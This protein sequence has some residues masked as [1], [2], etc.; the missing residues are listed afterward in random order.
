MSKLI[1]KKPGSLSFHKSSNID[2][3]D[4]GRMYGILSKGDVLDLDGDVIR[5]SAIKSFMEKAKGDVIRIPM[6]VEHNP[7]KVVKTLTVG[8]DIVESNGD[9]ITDTKFDITDE[10]QQK[11]REGVQSRKYT[12]MSVGGDIL[13]CHRGKGVRYDI[14][15][16]NLREASIVAQPAN[17]QALIQV[18]KSADVDL[19]AN[20]MN[21]KSWKEVVDE[22]ITNEM[23][24]NSSL[25]IL[26]RVCANKNLDIDAI[27]DIFY[28]AGFDLESEEL[29]PMITSAQQIVND[30]ITKNM[31][32]SNTANV[33]ES[34]TVDDPKTTINSNPSIDVNELIKSLN[35]KLN[36]H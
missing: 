14:A 35:N 12:G 18:C 34:K 13:K 26:F 30:R 9:L 36:K 3:D 31:A 19:F 24:P 32:E 1:N 10:F 6:L 5:K 17:P 22:Y 29:I 33:S 25:D 27:S 11:V 23:I 4:C 2:V 15:E 21:K 7:H 20:V 16:L 28:L 8:K